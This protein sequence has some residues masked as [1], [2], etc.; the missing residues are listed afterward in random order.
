MIKQLSWRK[1]RTYKGIYKMRWLNCYIKLEKLKI[2]NKQK[3]GNLIEV[4]LVTNSN[5]TEEQQ[6]QIKDLLLKYYR[7][8]ALKERNSGQ[9]SKVQHHIETGTHQSIQKK[10]K[11]TSF[12]EKK[13]IKT[14]VDGMLK[15]EII[16][17]SKFTW[18]AP[19]LSG[20]VFDIS[21]F[22]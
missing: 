9:N 14:E 12:Y 2:E 20:K 18:A 7:L 8:F 1:L 16:Q 21:R 11:R 17:K 15:E 13:V 3:K 5:L 19:I 4:N 10:L 6:Q 22:T